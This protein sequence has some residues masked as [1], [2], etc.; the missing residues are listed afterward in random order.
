LKM[1]STPSAD[2]NK[3]LESLTKC[4]ASAQ[5]S[6]ASKSPSE[7]FETRVQALLKRL[8]NHNPQDATDRPEHRTIGNAFVEL[9]KVTEQFSKLE[10]VAEQTRGCEA[11]S[12]DAKKW[13]DI[14]SVALDWSRKSLGDQQRTSIEKLS[15]LLSPGI[16]QEKPA[17]AFKKLPTAP[18][19]GLFP[20]LDAER[21]IQNSFDVKSASSVPPGFEQADAPQAHLGANKTTPSGFEQ[22]AT[23]R[24]HL[25]ALAHEDPNRILIV[26]RINR[27][28]FD[29]PTY[30]EKKF[31]EFGAVTRVF[32]A[33]SRVKRSEKQPVAR[34]RPAG[35]GFVLMESPEVA[36]AIASSGQQLMIND[37][38][39]QVKLYEPGSIGTG[40]GDIAE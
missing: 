16:V 8:D 13:Q 24:T 15:Q 37:V 6:G 33:H 32:V 21:K 2:F 14:T 35:V 18:P 23:L 30:L 10:Q 39:V 20:K 12:K 3:E 26:R 1:Q 40:K 9:I 19:P 36:L 25:E 29:S 22:G 31:S 34:V 38:E 5:D 4:I 7:A 28:G 11:V 17:S 27:L